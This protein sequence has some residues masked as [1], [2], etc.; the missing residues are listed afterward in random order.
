MKRVLSLLLLIPFLTVQAWA[1]RGGPY[2][3]MISRAAYSGTYGV[4]FSGTSYK[5]PDASNLEDPKD[6]F[7]EKVDGQSVTG[8][9]TMS[10][11]GAGA[12]SGRVLVFNAGM[13]YL[14]N[15]Q[16]VLN[17]GDTSKPGA[18]K[19][20]MFLQMSH[21]S[22]RNAFGPD[23]ESGAITANGVVGVDLVVN[24][25]L[26]LTLSTNYQTGLIAVSGTG[27][28]YKYVPLL[29][30]ITTD[31]KLT[32][33]TDTNLTLDGVDRTSNSTTS[34]TT[35]DASG[36]TVTTTDSSSVTGPSLNNTTGSTTTGSTRILNYQPDTVRQKPVKDADKFMELTHFEGYRENTT[37]TVLP[38]FTPPS[39]QTF[40][41]I[42][43]P[44]PSGNATQP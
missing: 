29:T 32:T 37:A 15:A 28:L 34:Q 10:V 18:G 6:S 4:V 30:S 41:Q 39:A 44:A 5:V 19:L 35:T 2:D 22:A 38:P 7:F 14:G 40:F 8:V 12:T 43:I 13:M 20:T 24:G 26:D 11:P 3:S 16:G 33:T 25:K 21:Y 23:P 1:L 36:A 31:S 17:A 27:D 42:D 9:M